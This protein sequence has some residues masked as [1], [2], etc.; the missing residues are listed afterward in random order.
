MP[1]PSPPTPNIP[2]TPLDPTYIP[3]TTA[4]PTAANL[5]IED[6]P[7][8]EPRQY[9]S[10]LEK[11]KSR[12]EAG[13]ILFPEAFAYIQTDSNEEEA[14]SFTITTPGAPTSF[15]IGVGANQQINGVTWV[16][17]VDEGG[18]GTISDYIIEFSPDFNSGFPEFLEK[19]ISTQV[20]YGVIPVFAPAGNFEFRVRAINEKGTGP[21]SNIIVVSITS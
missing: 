6:L 3:F 4:D 18:A 21:P 14:D 9:R 1:K 2:I 5:K 8:K 17:P 16:K 15:T 20:T 10:I 11:L 12:I 19:K 13:D 7:Q